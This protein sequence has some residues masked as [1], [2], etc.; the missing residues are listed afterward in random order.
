MRFSLFVYLHVF[1]SRFLPPKRAWFSPSLEYL[2]ARVGAFERFLSSLCKEPKLRYSQMLY[3]F[4]ATTLEFD[5]S[6]G[7]PDLGFGKVMR[8]VPQ[9]LTTERGQNVESFVRALLAAATQPKTKPASENVPFITG[10]E[11]DEESAKRAD[12][13]WLE[14]LPVEPDKGEPT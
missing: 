14:K 4:L 5:A 7:F 9:M 12:T 2:Q 1:L 10:F 6:D 8:S 3:N 11:D 13:N